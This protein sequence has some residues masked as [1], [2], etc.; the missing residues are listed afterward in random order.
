MM[1][2][3]LTNTNTT[4]RILKMAMVKAMTT[5]AGVP[6]CGGGIFSSTQLVAESEQ[7]LISRPATLQPRFVGQQQRILNGKNRKMKVLDLAVVAS[8]EMSRRKDGRLG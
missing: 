2:E 7:G 3:T 8:L 1:L 4:M 5:E 6:R